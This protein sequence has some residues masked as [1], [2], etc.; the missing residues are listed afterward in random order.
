MGAG[1]EGAYDNAKEAYERAILQNPTNP[2]PQVRIAQLAIGRWDLSV[3]LQHLSKAIA[4]KPNLGAAYFLRSQIEAQQGTFPQGI[5]DAVIAARLA[6]EDALAWYN[7]GAILYSAGSYDLAAQ[8]LEKA[9][10]LQNN[11]ANAIFI[12][13]LSYDKLGRDDSALAAIGAVAQLNPSDATV[14]QVLTNLKAGKSALEAPTPSKNV[15]Q[16][17]TK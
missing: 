10:S 1:I 2:L 12:L 4:L 16:K 3:A 8:A 14:Q 17:T 11:Y 9:V 7:L 13:G 15:P 5:E 6:T